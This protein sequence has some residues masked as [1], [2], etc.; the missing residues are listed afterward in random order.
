MKPGPGGVRIRTSP[1]G[2]RAQR[3]PHGEAAVVGLEEL[4]ASSVRGEQTVDDC[5]P[6]TGPAARRA[7]PPEAVERARALLGGHAGALITDVE[8]HVTIGPATLD[9][10][11]VARLRDRER[12]RNEV[13]E[14]LLERAGRRE[15]HERLGHPDVHLHPTLGQLCRQSV[16]PGGHGRMQVDRRGA[17]L[18]A[19]ARASASRPSTSRE[20]RP[21]SARAASRSALPSFPTSRSRFSR[22]SRSAASGVLE[23]MR[24]VGDEFVL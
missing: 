8:N 24:G 14:N 5:E 4:D 10:D 1:S 6:E 21:T 2:L 22:R 12:V 20:S 9:G 3:D 18:A 16:G 11:R 15:S 23:L 13:V 19:S 17:G 7:R